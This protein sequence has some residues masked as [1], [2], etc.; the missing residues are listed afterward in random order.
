MTRPLTPDATGNSNGTNLPEDPE[1]TTGD[2][3]HHPVALTEPPSIIAESARVDE[4]TTWVATD[5]LRDSAESTGKDSIETRQP[6]KP[7]QPSNTT[8]EA[9]LIQ[10]RKRTA[11]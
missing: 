4:D 7:G 11:V 6:G 1:D 5:G 2:D 8:E 3:E 9:H 10:Q